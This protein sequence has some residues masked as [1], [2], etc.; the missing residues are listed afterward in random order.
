MHDIFY[1][2]LISDFLL[3]I[4]GLL[5]SHV[6]GRPQTFDSYSRGLLTLH[7]LGHFGTSYS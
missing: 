1:V 4:V 2:V 7:N 6:P 3:G 5:Y